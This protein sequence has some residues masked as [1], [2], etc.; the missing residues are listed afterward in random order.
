MTRANDIESFPYD[1]QAAVTTGRLTMIKRVCLKT[2]AITLKPI[3]GATNISGLTIENMGTDHRRFVRAIFGSEVKNH[4]SIPCWHQPV[5]YINSRS[6][7]GR[8]LFTIDFLLGP[9]SKMIQKDEQSPSYQ[10]NTEWSTHFPAPGHILLNGHH[11]SKGQHPTKAPGTD[12]EHQQHQ[13]PTATHAENS[14][15]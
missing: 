5:V 1:H 12:S 9:G 8:P 15:M 3:N 11:R 2:F 14:V 4:T 10:S 7:T 6:G 13:R